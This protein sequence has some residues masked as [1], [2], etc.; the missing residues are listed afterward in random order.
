[1]GLWSN[2]YNMTP[3]DR[4][5]FM[6]EKIQSGIPQ[7]RVIFTLCALLYGLFAVL[8]RLLIDEFLSIFLLIRFGIVIPMTILFLAW[9]YHS[10]FVR[11][12]QILIVL[13]IVSG[14]AGIGFML[15]LYPDNFSYYG[16]LFLVIFTGYFLVKQDTAHAVFSGVLT[17][18]LYVL[19]YIVYHGFLSVEAMLVITFY[20]G[21]NLIGA[22]G[23]YQLDQI[24]RSN[25][26]QKRKI[27]RQNELLEERVREQRTELIQI[28]KAINSTRDAVV[29]YNPQGEITF[30]NNAYEALIQPN[31]VDSGSRLDPLGDIYAQVLNGQTWEGE[32]VIKA[33]SKKPLVFLVQAD[34]VRDEN[35]RI[36]GVVMTCRDIT[37][38]KMSVEALAHSHD[39][40]RYIIE[41]NRSAV[42]VHDRELKYLYVSQRYL[43]DYK[44]EERDII[45]K[46]HY[47]VFPDLPQKWK[48]VHQK[49]LR[50]EISSAEKDPYV[51]EDGT[52]DWTRWE[53]RPWYEA[54][55]S[56]GGIIVYTE[57]ITEHVQ[58]LEEL[59]NK[60]QSLRA[61]QE[62]AHVG[63][64]EF[65]IAKNKMTC[66][67]ESLNICGIKPSEYF[68]DPDTIL[69]CIHPDERDYVVVM[70]ERAMA[71]KRVLEYNCRI[72]RSDN[73]EHVVCIRVGPVFDEVGQPARIT[74]TVQDITERMKNENE[75]LYLSIHDHL[76]GLYNRRFFEQELKNLDT[77]DSLPLSI[78]MCDVNG[79][80][81]VNDSFGHD[82]GDRLLKKA[83]ETIKKVC[84][85]EDVIA[86]IG[87]DEFVLLLP[88]T[89]AYESVEIANHIKELASK[90]KVANI[91]LSISYGY[92]TKTTDK[93]SIVEIIANAENHMYRHKL[94]ERSSIRSKT[95]DLI[96]NA[97]FEKS[98]REA[99][100]SN[101]VS[102]I[103]QSIATKMNFNKDA[104]NQMKIAGL[105]HD[106]GKIGV[107]ETILNKPGNLTNDER[108]DI[109]RHPE[110]GWRLLSSTNEF[111]ELA[112]FVLNHHE[113]WDGSGYPN[114]LRG[115]AIQL[116]ARIIAVADAYDAMTS[117]RSY[118]KALSMEEA[119]KELIRCSGMQFDPGIVDVFVNQVLLNQDLA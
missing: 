95:T 93:Q 104:V 49:A 5:A 91:E 12:A 50:G 70:I 116:E 103:C 76:T 14:G 34:A 15:I 42:A 3:D 56:I 111:S 100:H 6:E 115:E 83:A 89:S 106:I 54:N 108:I 62:I 107:D 101:R 105:I 30:R 117:E 40:M 16:G 81:L 85:E 61:A 74:G 24:E 57:V 25:F 13:L 21:A 35:G 20:T 66:S 68:G 18:L 9:T 11:M 99:A 32:R 53:C 60:E 80:K 110:I 113:K 51:R 72:I 7:L 58:L 52:T 48:D 2:T 69:Q 36:A 63:S 73:E 37:E 88:K 79:L 114:G 102:S 22:F 86:R 47:E 77:T 94:Y 92:D 39:M 28:E 118:R 65:E 75:L 27:E 41:H 64:F 38:R 78:I 84:R 55:G 26:M 17:L 10:S 96:M 33:S 44:V 4:K 90:E 19:G 87:G 67:D 46:H 1:M 98:N 82:S 97:L 43:D 71:E 112:Q 29:I 8:D 59:R 109:E 31:P 23:N 45:G 119:I